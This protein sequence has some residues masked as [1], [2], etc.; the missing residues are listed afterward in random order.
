MHDKI[1]FEEDKWIYAST[2]LSRLKAA[3]WSF[4]WSAMS[5]TTLDLIFK[6]IQGQV[7]DKGSEGNL[8]QV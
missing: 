5:E 1:I 4:W 8:L 2:N 7:M 3:N 6:Y